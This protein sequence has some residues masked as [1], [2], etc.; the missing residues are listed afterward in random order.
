MK[1][2][3][4]RIRTVPGAED[5][6]VSAMT[7]LGFEGAQIEDN[8]PLTAAEK[9]QIYTYDAEDPVNDGVAY[10]S[11]YAPL[12]A[13]DMCVLKDESR[14]IAVLTGEVEETLAE[15]SVF[16]E[17]GEGTFTVSVMDDE[18]WKD[19]WKQYFHSFYLDDILIR[20]S[21]ETDDAQPDGASRAK[22]VL[23]IDP[24][25]AFG[26]GA[27]ETTQ[28]AIRAIR[29]QVEKKKAD[30]KAPV[31]L[32]IGTGSGILSILALMFGAS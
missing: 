23:Q 26:T 17:T 25:T 20:P 10:V 14:P 7:E 1:Y 28:L 30:G 2:A 18:S 21:W 13:G 27:H 16:C 12:E 11:F 31:M 6:L 3:R 5:I 32:D 8:V 4:F 9:E 22:Y 29:G 24:G 15:V 19:K